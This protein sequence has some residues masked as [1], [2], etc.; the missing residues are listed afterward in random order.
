MKVL[1]SIDNSMVAIEEAIKILKPN[2]DSIDIITIVDSESVVQEEIIS[3]DITEYTNISEKIID[4][5]ENMLSSRG[6]EN[7]TR[8]VLVGEIRQEII[9]HISDNGPFDMIIVGSRGL[10]MIKKL[11]LGSVSEYLVQHSPIPV[12][13]AKSSKALIPSI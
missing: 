4:R 13:V 5:A 9:K 1:L 8:K 7:I 6:F 12:Y 3:S 2:R 11:M 10:G